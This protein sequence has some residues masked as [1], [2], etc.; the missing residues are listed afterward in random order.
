[1]EPTFLTVQNLQHLAVQ[2]A[3]LGVLALGAA[4]IVLAGGADFSFA[5]AVGVISVVT[6]E[7][8][9]M[10]SSPTAL[11][12]AFP[13]GLGIAIL[14]AGLVVGLSM[15]PIVATLGTLVFLRGLANV[16]SR[17]TPVFDVPAGFEWAGTAYVGAIPVPAVVA[18]LVVAIDV[19]MMA[20]SR[21]GR[22]VYATGSNPT[23]TR[24]AGVNPRRT[25][26][27]AYL[28]GGMHW[29]VA[30]ILLT[31]Q[32]ASGQPSLATGWEVRVFTAVFLGG[33]A[34]I[35]GSGSLIGVLFAS[36][37]LAV[38]V[39]G[40][41]LLHIVSYVQLIVSGT[42]M[43]LAILFTEYFVQRRARAERERLLI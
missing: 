3:P 24:L 18:A 29:A 8:A 1:M 28:V 14:N 40:M 20:Y 30:G 19:V 25:L 17:G 21:F 15:S 32:V 26:V 34:L 7:V 10:I 4:I 22:Y 16:L 39:N 37:L 23:A 2:W 33:V 27:L 31:S 42:L 38:L 9:S 35:G 36:L 12:L 5:A 13:V 11:L 43:L 6:A 41:D